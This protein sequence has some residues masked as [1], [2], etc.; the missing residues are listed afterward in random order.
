[1]AQRVGSLVHH[2]ALGARRVENLALFY[3]RALGLML[4]K[5]HRRT[6]GTVRSIWLALDQGQPPKS[7][8]MIEE[9]A[10]LDPQRPTAQVA[11]GWFL[12]AFSVAAQQR[13]A[14]EAAIIA[15]GGTIDSRSAH[16]TY[17]RDIEN[18]RFAISCY[19]FDD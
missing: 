13:T 15:A 11:P 16:S 12:L 9:T 4:K 1:M 10:D 3:Q 7:M 8:L 14:T 19:P 2:V 5:E 17:A 18:N 6:D